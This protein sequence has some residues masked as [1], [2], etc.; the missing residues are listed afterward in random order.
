MENINKDFE[1]DKDYEAI[2]AFLLD[3]DCLNKL[4][5]WIS[6]FSVFDILKITRKEI[7]HSNMLAWLMDPNENHGL[8]D[9][10]LKGILQYG[11][12]RHS[13]ND[14]FSTLLM[15]CYDFFILREWSNIDILAVSKSQKFVLCIENKID[16]GENNNQLARYQKIVEQSY[17]GYEKMF[18]FLTPDGRESSKPDV[19]FAMGYEELLRILI[20]SYT[21]RTIRPEAKLMIENY[22][23]TIRRDIV[24]DEKLAQVCA[25]IYSKH[26]RALD[27]IYEYKPDQALELA[28]VVRKWCRQK[29]S[30]N[31]ILYTG[32]NDSKT[33]TRFRT[34]KMNSIMPD[35]IDSLSEWGTRNYY[36]YEIKYD[37]EKLKILLAFSSKDIPDNLRKQC[38]NIIN[39][40]APKKPLAE[41]WI[42]RT[43]PIANHNKTIDD[44]S[45]DNIF[46]I[47]DMMFEKVKTFEDDLFK[48][49]QEKD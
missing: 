39:I 17:S 13:V 32:Q 20:N 8:G 35:A 34:E 22:I 7:R 31:E 4:D 21:K 11:V 18:V 27:L 26:K 41:G 3:I 44:I 45:E 19:W 25:E 42:W 37:G 49:I 46:H 24:G 9:V 43:H 23:D 30:E 2:K 40:V 38:S 5:E 15:D 33:Y 28:F 29:L 14:V 6:R 48:R 47:L 36:F 10:V 16:S 1:P 12:S